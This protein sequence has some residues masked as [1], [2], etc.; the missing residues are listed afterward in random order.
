MEAL[1]NPRTSALLFHDR[2]DNKIKCLIYKEHASLFRDVPPV[3][4]DVKINGSVIL[5][6]SKGRY[7]FAITDIEMPGI[8]QKDQIVSV[9]FLTNTLRTSIEAYSNKI[10]GK[11][12]KNPTKNPA[13]Y[14]HL[15]LKDANANEGTVTEIIE[16]QLPPNIAKG[17]PFRLKKSDK[18]SIDGQFSIFPGVSRYQIIA[19][20]IQRVLSADLQEDEDQ[21]VTAVESYFSQFQGFSTAKECEIQM[22]FEQRRPDIVLIDSEGVF[23]AIAECK[24]NNVI[25]YG[26]EQLKSYLCATDTRFGVFANRTDRDTW[27][28]YKTASPQSISTDRSF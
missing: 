2:T 19:R 25:G 22:P 7:R 4:N 10:Q 21:V 15:Y 16:C 14:I 13:G 23:A 11:I 28:F 27:I 18:V 8:S 24:R 1:L 17:L 9:S 3:G 20:D 26:L 6:P 5:R 12:F